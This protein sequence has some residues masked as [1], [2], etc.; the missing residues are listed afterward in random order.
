MHFVLV[1]IVPLPK[2]LLPVLPSV[3]DIVPLPILPLPIVLPPD[4]AFA[5][6][7]VQAWDWESVKAE[8]KTLVNQVRR[9]GL[10]QAPHEDSSS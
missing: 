2:V 3:A 9:Q 1:P 8:D 7:C 6:P 4:C 5:L 10:L